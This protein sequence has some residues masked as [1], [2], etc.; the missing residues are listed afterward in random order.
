MT[1]MRAGVVFCALLIL[2]FDAM[3][4]PCMWCGH[5]TQCCY[6]GLLAS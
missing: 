5:R 1:C 6:F 3:L 4:I 2:D